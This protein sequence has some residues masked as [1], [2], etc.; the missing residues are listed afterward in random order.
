MKTVIKCILLCFTGMTMTACGGESLD[1]YKDKLLDSVASK[2]KTTKELLIKDLDI[3]IDSMSLAYFLVEDSINIIEKN[4]KEELE[5][6]EKWI[7]SCQEEIKKK[8]D[9]N[10]TGKGGAASSILASIN[11]SFIK[12]NRDYIKEAESEISKLTEKYK[13]ELSKYENRDPKEKIYNIFCYRASL[14][15]PITQM[16]NSSREMSFFSPD[17]K[18]Y[19]KDVDSDTKK[20]L[21]QKK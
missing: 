3:N 6:K 17:G 1:D 12:M 4:Y 10:K 2:F 19:I 11:N 15:N 18:T 16:H 7:A 8:E 13:S 20:Y 21:E 14:K 9:E 5:K